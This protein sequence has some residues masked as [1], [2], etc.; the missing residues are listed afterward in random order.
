MA[1][2]V[3]SGDVDLYVTVLD[4]RYP[5][6]LDFDYSSTKQGPDDILITSN[7]AFWSNNG[8]NTSYG[9]LFMVGVVAN[10][11]NVNYT[12]LMTGPNHY[13]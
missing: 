2:S 3:T 7:D 10:T 11:P 1:A 9:V 13:A 12:L 4:S 8:Y 5:T 6:T